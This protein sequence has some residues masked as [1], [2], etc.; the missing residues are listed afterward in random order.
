MCVWCDHSHLVLRI[1]PH[2]ARAVCGVSCR[3]SGGRCRSDSASESRY[4]SDCDSTVRMAHAWGAYQHGCERH[5][6]RSTCG[7]ASTGTEGDGE[8]RETVLVC[9][10]CSVVRRCCSCCLFPSFLVASSMGVTQLACTAMRCDWAAQ[11][12]VNFTSIQ[13]EPTTTRERRR[14]TRAGGERNNKDD[15]TDMRHVLLVRCAIAR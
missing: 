13:S 10:C 3:R 5:H 7:P 12:T 2:P 1:V 14:R 9:A 4:Y 11:C 8:E 6:A 15:Q